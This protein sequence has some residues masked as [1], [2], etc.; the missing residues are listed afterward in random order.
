MEERKLNAYKITFDVDRYCIKYIRDDMPKGYIGKTNKWA[1]DSST[2]LKYLLKK[3]PEKSGVCVFK[4]GGTGKIVSIE[5]S[6]D[7]ND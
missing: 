2:A 3:K 5:K 6:N 4:R 7:T 1:K